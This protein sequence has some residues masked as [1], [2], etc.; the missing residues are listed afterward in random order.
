MTCM[1]LHTHATAR[2]EGG[3][4]LCGV[5]T[6]N[7][8][9]SLRVPLEIKLPA[10]RRAPSPP[11][12]GALLFEIPAPEAES[13][14]ERAFGIKLRRGAR[15]SDM[16]S[17]EPPTPNRPALVQSLV[18]PPAAASEQAAFVLRR[19]ETRL[20]QTAVLPLSTRPP[21]QAQASTQ[22]TAPLSP[23]GSLVAPSPK[24]CVIEFGS[25]SCSEDEDGSED[26][27]EPGSLAAEC[28]ARW[29]PGA[30]LVSLDDLWSRLPSGL[31]D[32]PFTCHHATTTSPPPPPHPSVA[33][34]P[35]PLCPGPRCRVVPR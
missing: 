19:P 9:R 5:E 15:P 18:I 33:Q 28:R 26:E 14:G 1:R 2:V 34:L 7:S 22:Q 23:K 4:C 25:P 20:P 8:S 35:P 10:M 12:A 29:G 21:A 30:V 6:E 27:Y 13:R 31:R 16:P 11:R 24:R 3:L 17:P 32:H